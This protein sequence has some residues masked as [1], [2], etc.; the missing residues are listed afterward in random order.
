MTAEETLAFVRRV[1]AVY[2][3]F[4]GPDGSEL[5]WRTD[6][7]YA[8][9]TMFAMCNDLF[10]WGSAD[11]EKITP[12]NVVELE[13]AVEDC[14]KVD[15]VVGVCEA[16]SLFCCR[17]RG[18]RPQGAAYPKDKKFW[19]LFDACGPEREVGLGNPK[20]HPNESVVEEKT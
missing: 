8:P 12:E 11:L 6:G 1:L 16:T 3:G 2:D 4:D 10:F 9:V 15:E 7:E 5:W 17:V 19:P 14:K 18:M 20:G 13:R